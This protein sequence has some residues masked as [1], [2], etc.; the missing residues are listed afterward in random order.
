M[1]LLQIATA[2]FV[3][4]CDGQVLQIATAFFNYKVRHCLLQ[5]ATDLTKCDEFITNCDSTLNGETHPRRPTGSQSGR[6]KGRDESFQVWAKEPLG[7]DT[8]RTISKN[9]SGCWLLIGH[10]KCIIIVPNRRTVSPEF[11][12]WVR[13]WRLLLQSRLVWLMHQRNARSQ[14]TFSLT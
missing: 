2:Y 5:I 6:E 11:F 9:L 8:H 12:S 1:E 7:T 10:K 4:K 13:T 14:E 3:T